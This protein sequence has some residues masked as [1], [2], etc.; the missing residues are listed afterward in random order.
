MEK[1]REYNKLSS[2]ISREQDLTA[3]DLRNQNG[4]IN[5]E[6]EER[7]RETFFKR[8]KR[9]RERK[10][11]VASIHLQRNDTRTD[12]ETNYSNKSR[13]S[14]LA[15]N[16]SILLKTTDL[17]STSTEEDKRTGNTID[18]N[19]CTSKNLLKDTEKASGTKK[20]DR[21]TFNSLQQDDKR[22][23]I[24]NLIDKVHTLQLI[25]KKD[26]DNVSVSSRT[27]DLSSTAKHDA[28]DTNNTSSSTLQSSSIQ[29]VQED[30]SCT[31]KRRNKRA[32]NF[33][34]KNGKQTGLQTDNVK[35][36]EQTILQLI[37][38]CNNVSSKTP[39]LPSTNAVEHESI[40]YTNDKGISTLQSPK[41]TLSDIDYDFHE[42]N[43][44]IIETFAPNIYF[45]LCADDRKTYCLVCDKTFRI[46]N[47]SNLQEHLCRHIQSDKHTRLL[48][49]M[50]EDDKKSLKAG[51]LFSKLGLARECMRSKNDIVEC[52]LCDSKNFSSKVQN[53][54]LSLYEHILSS[55]HQNFK[56][57]W[58]SSVKN[59][60]RD[61]HNH[62]RSVY[63][64]KKYCCEFCSYESTSEICF[65]K[66][67]R[68][69]YHT[70]R[71]VDIPDH[72][73]KFKFYYCAAC[74]LLWFG[75]SDMYD[76][77]CEQTEHIRR[78]IYGSDLDHL[79]EQIIQLLIMANQN[80]E[81]FL[82]Q[83]NSIC[84]DK[85]LNYILYGLITE[86][87]KYIPNIKAYPF[88]SRISDL[89]FPDSDIDIFLDCGKSNLNL[90]CKLHTAHL[91][92]YMCMVCIKM[93]IQ[94]LKFKADYI[95]YCICYKLRMLTF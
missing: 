84:Y 5:N 19:T 16:T 50:I 73:E 6:T 40:E 44:A 12:I 45:S 17:L 58:T 86:L 52:L 48:S 60:L 64:A 31:R 9:K 22:T 56:V 36:E 55:T 82:T 69:P 27:A 51:R 24:N 88:G 41:F 91:C 61:V 74:Q 1:T 28:R 35:D 62:F 11:K 3:L 90:Y 32:Y 14:H 20:E 26:N 71:L 13:S 18:K 65:A 46:Q 4:I 33:L 66:H 76:Q 72:G 92:L 2:N 70:T 10:K 34:Q 21:E 95:H 67:L 53:D 37:D 87:Q 81:A 78:I 93:F 29:D 80:A 85:M 68:V 77:H 7:T 94:I 15:N 8:K 79:P 83:S 59:V 43:H 89:G 23:A 54:N 47:S 38:N 39:D 63:N 49:Q 42:A 25:R 75:S 30:S 57:S